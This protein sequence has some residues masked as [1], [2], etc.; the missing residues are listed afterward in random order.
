[1]L[2]KWVDKVTI[3]LYLVIRNFIVKALYRFQHNTKILKWN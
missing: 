1:M 3:I 2:G